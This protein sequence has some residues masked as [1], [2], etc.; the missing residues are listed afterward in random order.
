MHLHTTVIK[1]LALFFSAASV[2]ALS[3]PE[4]RPEIHSR[5]SVGY[6]SSGSDPLTKLDIADARSIQPR[7]RLHTVSISTFRRFDALG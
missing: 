4:R 7:L 2:V 3:L 5:A 6:G 1:V